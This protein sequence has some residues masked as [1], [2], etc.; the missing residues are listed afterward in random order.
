MNRSKNSSA[1][2]RKILPAFLMP[3]KLLNFLEYIF[4]VDQRLSHVDAINLVSPRTIK[5]RKLEI[6]F[7]HSKTIQP[8]K[9]ALFIRLK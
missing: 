8:I 3:S 2:G 5:Y 6:Y 7:V 1:S 9:S 4:S